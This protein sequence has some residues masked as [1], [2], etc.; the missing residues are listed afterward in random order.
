MLMALKS[1]FNV[2]SITRGYASNTLSFVDE[3]G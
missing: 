3:G 2:G 1:R